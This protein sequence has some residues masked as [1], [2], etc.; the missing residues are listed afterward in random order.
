[1]KHS[2]IPLRYC[3]PSV[4]NQKG[5][6]PFTLLFSSTIDFNWIHFVNS[7]RQFDDA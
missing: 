7:Y 4:L 6:Y 2:G 1:M 3:Q 5:T